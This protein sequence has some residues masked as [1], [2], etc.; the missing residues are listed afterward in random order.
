VVAILALLFLAVPF[1]EIYVILQVGHVVGLLPTLALLIVIS[2]A[3]A[4]LVK[5]EGLGVW[6]RAQERMEMGEV[7]GRE[8]VDGVLVLVAG[9][10][11]FTPG[12]VTDALGILLLLPPV[13]AGVRAIATRRLTYRVTDGVID[14]RSIER[15][16][17]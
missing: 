14:A 17:R 13:R 3:G 11:L 12:F 5:R 9:A 2:T 6:R 4:A 7:P 15:R 1:V 8:L 16:S 10:L